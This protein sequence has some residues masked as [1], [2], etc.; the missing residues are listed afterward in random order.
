MGIKLDYASVYHPQT[1]GQVER[2]NGLIMSGIKPRLVQS[3]KESNTHWVE[4]LDSVLWGLRTT[5]K[6][7]TG[8][9]PFFMVYGAEVVL[10]CDIIHDSP[11]VRMYE[12]R[13]AELDRRDSLD[14][15]KEERDVAKV[16]SAFYEQ[17]AR[18][19]QSRE[20]RAKTYNVGNFFYTCWRRKR[21]N[22]SPSGRVPSSLTKFSLEERTACVLH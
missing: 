22:S 7:T 14:A 21:T 2:A 9:T 11:R 20:V 13:E 16:H 1:N 8:Y 18:I 15:L 10:P 17:Q 19:Y 6:R 4:E 12:E 3:L 5:P